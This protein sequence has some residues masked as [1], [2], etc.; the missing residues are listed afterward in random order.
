MTHQISTR[1][2]Q[3]YAGLV[4]PRVV[5]SFKVSSSDLVDFL[6]DRLRDRGPGGGDINTIY[7]P[8]PPPKVPA[9]R[10]GQ[11]QYNVLVCHPYPSAAHA[12]VGD[13]LIRVPKGLYARF[14]PNGEYADV[15]EDVWAQVDDAT[16]S[17]Q[18]VRAYQEEIEVSTEKGVELY[19][20]IEL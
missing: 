16:A 3:V 10:A 12:P 20:S 2:E 5:P 13:V 1:D 6:K 4:I 18:I 19:I 14:A 15:I 11:K 9:D 7:V 8:V 17:G